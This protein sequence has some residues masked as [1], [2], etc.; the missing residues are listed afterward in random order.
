MAEPLAD[1]IA[2][3][4]GEF[5][6]LNE[7]R[8]V[9]AAEVIVLEQNAR[10]APELQRQLESSGIIIRSARNSV[11]LR[12]LVAAAVDA[13]KKCIAVLD[14]NGRPGEC[15]PLLTWARD[16]KIRVIVVGYQGIELLEPSLQELGATTV[17]LPPVAGHR[18]GDA[19]RRL[20]EQHPVQ[21]P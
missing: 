6:F 17:L 4:A 14:P 13:R 18:I 15:L 1:R 20:L 2:A 19:C 5:E 7:V 12:Q 16:R 8:V 10:W 9:L 11:G 21:S 3:P